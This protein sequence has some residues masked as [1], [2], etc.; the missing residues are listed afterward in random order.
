MDY[1]EWKSKLVEWLINNN[2]AFN[3]NQPLISEFN[4]FV[5]EYLDKYFGES[6]FLDFYFGAIKDF[7]DAVNSSEK[8]QK[9]DLLKQALSKAQESQKTQDPHSEFYGINSLIAAIKEVMDNLDNSSN[10]TSTNQ[11]P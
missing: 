10:S 5:S 2:I 1:C 11:D 8:K 7:H 6:V 9:G 4:E 3:N